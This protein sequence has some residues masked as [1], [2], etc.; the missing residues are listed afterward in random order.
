MESVADASDESLK[1]S[2]VATSPTATPAQASPLVKSTTSAEPDL[3]LCGQ[4]HEAI[5]TSDRS[6]LL[7][8]ALAKGFRPPQKSKSFSKQG[9]RRRAIGKVRGNDAGSLGGGHGGPS[10][11][12]QEQ[13]GF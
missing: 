1:C 9:P 2:E 5:T 3:V 12:R 13:R 10:F 8:C 6:C 11:V 7:S 4:E